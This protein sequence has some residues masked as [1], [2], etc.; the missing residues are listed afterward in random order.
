MRNP[1]FNKAGK[2][3]KGG[4]HDFEQ[5]TQDNIILLGNMCIKCGYVKNAQ[6]DNSK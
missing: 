2:C 1:T 6:A 5:K 4:E 3:P